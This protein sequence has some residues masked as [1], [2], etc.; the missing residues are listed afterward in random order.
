MSTA[1]GDPSLSER[2][3]EILQ[4]LASGLHTQ[5][6]ATRIGLSAETVKSDTKRAIQKLG[7]DT[8]VHAVAIAIRRALIE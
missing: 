7:A 8:R 6:V 1:G 3:R 4:L 5:E 2:E